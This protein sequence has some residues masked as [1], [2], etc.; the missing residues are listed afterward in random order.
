M[1]VTRLITLMMASLAFKGEQNRKLSKYILMLIL[2][3]ALNTVEG[4]AVPPLEEV[5]PQPDGSSDSDSDGSSSDESSPAPD[6]SGLSFDVACGMV[7]DCKLAEGNTG[8]LSQADVG[9]VTVGNFP[10]EKH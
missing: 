10:F 4:V 9:D 3:S 1:A 6:L 5:A 8:V 7:S 2:F